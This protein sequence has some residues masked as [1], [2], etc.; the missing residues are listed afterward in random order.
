MGRTLFI[1]P[2]SFLLDELPEVTIT[3]KLFDLIFQ[4]IAVFDI[5]S[6]VSVESTVFA[7]ISGGK[8]RFHRWRPS[9]ELFFFDF[10]EDI[11]PRSEESVVRIF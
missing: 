7:F 9:K 3:N 11:H 6:I 5:M 2:S 8:R 4:G 10:H 1:G